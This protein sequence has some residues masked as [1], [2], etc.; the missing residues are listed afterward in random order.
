[1]GSTFL[2]GPKE[3]AVARNPFQQLYVGE[4]ID[5]DEFVAIFSAKLVPHAMPLFQPGH[6]VLSG[7]QGSGKSMLFKLLQPEVRCAY[8]KSGDEFPIPRESSQFIGAGININTARCNE[9]GNRRAEPGDSV[10]EL[11]FGDFFNYAVSLDIVRSVR[12]LSDE[13]S[14]A[15]ELGLKLD[16]RRE[17]RFCQI[18]AG[19]HV[20][21]GY[22]RDV[23]SLADIEQRMHR[24]LSLYR[25]FLNANDRNLDPSVARTKTAAGE[26]MKVLVNAFKT[27]GIA[28]KNVEFYVHIDQYEELETIKGQGSEAD[29]RSVVNKVIS[30]DPTLSYR[31]GTRGYAWRRHLNVFGSNGFLEQ[32]RDYKLV[33]IDAKLRAQEV[34]ATSIYPE[35]ANDVFMRRLKYT[36][37]SG[38]AR[39]RTT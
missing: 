37:S 7:V 11:M 3:L 13:R 20:W 15:S 8:A 5:P 12:M 1:M 9:F 6:V 26:P 35:F 38:S 10:Q 18:V 4:K 24:R 17:R 39:T 16:D 22:L 36:G 30:R 21:E 27:A 33:E 34:K 29:Y 19:D 25:R 28:P 14:I 31:I 2:P 23:L 32:D